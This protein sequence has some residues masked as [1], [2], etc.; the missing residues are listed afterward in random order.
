VFPGVLAREGRPPRGA[1]GAWPASQ[2]A[3]SRALA[4]GEHSASPGGKPPGP[5]PGTPRGALARGEHSAPLGASLRAHSPEPPGARWPGERAPEPS[6]GPKA[7]WL[8]G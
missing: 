1:D 4:R 3:P 2:Q 6:G 7:R 5:Q 8:E